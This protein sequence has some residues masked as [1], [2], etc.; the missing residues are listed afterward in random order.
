MN[1]EVEIFKMVVN[2]CDWLVYKCFVRIK[3]WVLEWEFVIC[4][5]KWVF[6]LVDLLFFLLLELFF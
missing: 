4:L 5:F 6:C 3:F 2:S 1:E